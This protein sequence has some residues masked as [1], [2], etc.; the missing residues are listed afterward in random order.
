M[1]HRTHRTMCALVKLEAFGVSG[2]GLPGASAPGTRK[3]AWPELLRNAGLDFNGV[4]LPQCQPLR[5]WGLGWQAWG[6]F[7]LCNSQLWAN[8]V[9]LGVVVQAGSV[10]EH[11]DDM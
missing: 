4:H 2:F 11:G 7:Q 9:S 6:L 3:K 8:G 1:K 5:I 10:S